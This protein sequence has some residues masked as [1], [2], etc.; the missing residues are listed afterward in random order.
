VTASYSYDELDR[1]T[2]LTHTQGLTPLVT[3]QY[4]YN[5][6]NNISNWVNATGIHG[7]GYDSVDRLT[8]AT[9][10]PQPNESYAYDGVGNRTSSHL[11]ASYSYQ[12]FNKLTTTATASYAYDNNGN[13]ISRTDSLGATTFSWNEENQLKQV[14]LP[15]GLKVNYKYDGL[16]RRIQRTTSASAN[17]R[18]V[19]DGNDVLLDLNADW[20]VATTYLSRPGIDNHLRQTSATTGVSYYLTDHL[21]STS[22]LTDAAGNIVEQI[23]NDSF[24]NGPGITRTRY[25]YTGRERDPDTG[26]YYYRAR[27]YDPQVGRFI[28]EDPLGLSGGLNTYAYVENDPIGAVD[29]LGLW[30]YRPGGPYHP[31]TGVKTSCTYGDSCQTLKGKMAVLMRV[32]A[33]HQGWDRQVPRP[34]GG[35]RHAGEIAD[36]WRAYANCQSIYEM[37]CKNDTPNC[38][39][40]LRIPIG[41]SQ[42]EL[43]SK[44]ESARQMHEFWKKVTLGGYL[45]GSVLTG[46]ALSGGTAASAPWL[47]PIF[48]P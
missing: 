12:P 29:P 34:H 8:S 3:N 48:A 43:D 17:E 15:T 5:N 11:S 1:L 39:V 14:T 9:N 10:V 42:D 7:Y 18:Y 22:A 30:G 27:F 47:V 21:G 19:Y 37:K 23:S 24:G 41:Q 26:F 38:P 13:L 40:P 35:N 33:S 31:P 4:Q 6:A 46:G 45:V 16:G 44:A 36:F 32:I 25:G 2:A 28:S 20:S